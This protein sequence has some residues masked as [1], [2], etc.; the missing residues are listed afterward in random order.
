MESLTCEPSST[1]FSKGGD[2]SS[3]TWAVTIRRDRGLGCKAL[4]RIQTKRALF[5]QANQPKLH[6]APLLLLIFQQL[7]RFPDF[8]TSLVFA[9]ADVLAA[10]AVAD[11]ARRRDPQPR[12]GKARNEAKVSEKST[13]GGVDGDGAVPEESST[14]GLLDPRLAALVYLWNPFTL[15][16]C[17]ARSTTAITNI[18]VVFALSAAARRGLLWRVFYTVCCH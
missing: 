13:D 2:L 14:S 3:Q 1:F 9:I 18:F 11:F 7:S 15:G 17:L 12:E 6:Q 16:S 4:S 8:M 10:G 5:F